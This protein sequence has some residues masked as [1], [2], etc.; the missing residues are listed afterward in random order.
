[1]LE[2]YLACSIIGGI[3]VL[4][5]VSGGFEGFD[6]DTDADADVDMDA[7]ADAEVDDVDFGTHAGKNQKKYNQSTRQKKLWLPFFSFKF[8]TFGVCFF[9][10]TGLALTLL[11]PDLGQGVISLTAIAVG[12]AIG[13]AMAG[14]LRVLGGN[15][16]NSLT[17]TEDF[18]GVV[19]QVEI[20]FDKNSRGKVQ[21][22]VKG[23]T[24]GFSAM[25]EEETQFQQGDEVLV[26]SLYDNKVWV[27]SADE[28]KDE[29][30]R[31]WSL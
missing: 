23:S 1:M 5:S 24:I 20:P 10:L 18:V 9:G 13:T 15:Y 26:V 30:E 27:I 28:L 2:I 19:G 29:D 12:L 4:L 14:L 21:L 16:T 22:P 11:A 25:T 6:F 31:K 3:F 17:Q 8:W 7:D